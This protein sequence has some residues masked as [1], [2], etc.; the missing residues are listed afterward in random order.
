MAQK[1]L[2]RRGSNHFCWGGNGGLLE[3]EQFLPVP[4][5]AW[6]CWDLP[7]LIFTK[8]VTR[9]NSRNISGS[10]FSYIYIFLEAYST[11]RL[12]EAYYRMKRH[13]QNHG[14]GL[15]GGNVSHFSLERTVNKDA[16]NFRGNGP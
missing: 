12:F 1:H 10:Q 6:P 14:F 15:V 2:C 8:S 7:S 4:K 3:E 13:R 5:G 11:V 9:S 16:G